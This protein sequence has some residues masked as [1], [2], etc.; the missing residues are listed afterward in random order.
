MHA[1]SRQYTHIEYVHPGDLW[2]KINMNPGS[3]VTSL[4]TFKWYDTVMIGS[5]DS[6]AH[7]GHKCTLLHMYLWTHINT[8]HCTICT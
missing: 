3:S 5:S 7:V 8:V 4:I 6:K 2:D 1:E